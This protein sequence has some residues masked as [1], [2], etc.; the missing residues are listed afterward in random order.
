MDEYMLKSEDSKLSMLVR[1]SQ[2][3]TRTKCI[4]IANMCK[5]GC[6]RNRIMAEVEINKII[7]F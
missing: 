6:I 3:D 5:M 4:Y 2:D 1:V 7:C